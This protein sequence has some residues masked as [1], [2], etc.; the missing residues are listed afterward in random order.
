[1][2]PLFLPTYIVLSDTTDREQIQRC[3]LSLAD[4]YRVAWT[5]TARQSS[6]AFA[7]IVGPSAGPIHPAIAARYGGRFPEGSRAGLDA[8][9]YTSSDDRFEHELRTDLDL[10]RVDYAVY[11]DECLLLEDGEVDEPQRVF[12]YEYRGEVGPEA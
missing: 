6:W 8:W 2:Q 4:S 12:E 7:R 11:I 10:S 3:I 1:M 5:D 9:I